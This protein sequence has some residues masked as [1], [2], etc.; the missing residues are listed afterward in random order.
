MIPGCVLWSLAVPRAHCPE[1]TVWLT[2][3]MMVLLIM[4]SLALIQACQLAHIAL[5]SCG[6]KFAEALNVCR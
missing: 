6:V 3:A 1:T 2:T 4:P 5:A